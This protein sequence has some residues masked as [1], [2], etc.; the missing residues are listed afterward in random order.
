MLVSLNWIASEKKWREREREKGR[1]IFSLC[2]ISS[3]SNPASYETQTHS[4]THH[5]SSWPGS[6]T[7]H[8]VLCSRIMISIS[9]SQS[10]QTTNNHAEWLIKGYFRNKVTFVCNTAR[11]SVLQLRR[12]HKTSF[13]R[14]IW[15]R[16]GWWD[17][18]QW[19]FPIVLTN[20]NLKR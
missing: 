2:A 18:G 17:E 7:V 13:Y 8:T 16:K 20:C 19:A 9:L 3:N 11:L 15:C 5:P 1:N 12:L 10:Y 6:W 14:C 4:I